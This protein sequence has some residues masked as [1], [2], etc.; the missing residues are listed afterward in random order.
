MTFHVVCFAWIFFRANS[1]ER[2]AAVIEQLFT[3]WGRPSPLVTTSVVVAILVGI[4]GQY[5]R[6]TT[7]TNVMPDSSACR[8]WRRRLLSPS[9]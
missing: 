6:Q 2:A 3:A 5:L 8:P 1:F 9:G 7:L 4:G